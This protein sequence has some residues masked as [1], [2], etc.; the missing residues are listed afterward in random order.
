MHLQISDSWTSTVQH[1][2]VGHPLSSH[3]TSE[4]ALSNHPTIGH[5][6]SNHWTTGHTLSN[7]W[8]AEPTILIL[9]N[10]QTLEQNTAGHYLIC[11][12]FDGFSRIFKIYFVQRKAFRP[13]APLSALSIFL[14]PAVVGGGGLALVDEA[15]RIPNCTYPLVTLVI[16]CGT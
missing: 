8:T 3:R 1:L 14:A 6:L 11:Q 13:K 2:T 5:A 4:D 15:T 10:F 7:H 16:V 12:Y 9:F